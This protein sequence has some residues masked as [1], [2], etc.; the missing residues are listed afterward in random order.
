MTKLDKVVFLRNPNEVLE[1]IIKNFIKESAFNRRTQL[2]QGIYW[3]GPLVGFASGTDPLFFEYK[4]LIGPFHQTPREIIATALREKGQAL[5]FSEIEQI[6]V[7]SWILPATEETR[8]SNRKEESISIQTLGLHERFRRSLQRC[9][10]E[11]CH[12]IFREYGAR[13][14]GPRP[15]AFF[16]VPP[17]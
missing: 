14:R 13:C 15:F 7:I 1:Q 9:F 3:E 2:D 17:G 12:R 6:S 5:P 8:K 10:E 11:A 16:Q 4:T